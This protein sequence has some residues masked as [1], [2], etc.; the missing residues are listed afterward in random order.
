MP[1]RL[2]PID[3]TSRDF[4]SI[5][6][7]LETFAKR[8]YADTYKDFN[9][10]SFGSLMLDTVAYIGDI[11][12]FYL[13][14]QANESFLETAVEYNNVVKLA[15][16]LGYKIDRNP[17]SYGMLTFYIKVPASTTG[18][19]PDLNFAPT[20]QAGSTFSSTG[21][22]SYSL[23][24]DVVFSQ[25]TN[26]V[27]VGSVDSTS[28]LPTS[29]VIRAKGRAVSGRTAFQEVT[30]GSFERFRKVELGNQN[31]TEVISVMDSEGHRYYEVDNLSQNII[32]KA[33]RNTTATK[34]TVANILKAVPVARRFVV[35][36]TDTSTY[37]QFGYGSDSELVSEAVVDPSNL[38]LDL[39]GRNY[40]TD[41][42]FDP[43]KLISSDKFGIAPANT[44][45]RIGYRVNTT[46]D[47]NAGA[48]TI[49]VVGNP[50]VK[51]SSPATLPV[52]QRTAVLNSLEVTNEAP[53]VG[54]VSMPSADDIK[55]RVFGFYATQHRAVTTED[56]RAMCYA[57]P[58][59][60][61]AVR[62][63]NLV[64]DFDAF[65]RNL[66][67][68][69]ISENTSGKLV[70]ANQTLK[71]NLKN[72]IL[73]YKM[74]NDTV[75]ILDARIIN[76]GIKYTL[77]LDMNTSR[78]TA[79]AQANQNIQTYLAR[80]RFEI[81][82]PIRINDIYRQLNKV[83]GVVDVMGVEIVSKNGGRYAESD[84]DPERAMSADGRMIRADENTI[85]ELKFPSLDI[86]GSVR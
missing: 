43:T 20:L 61:G 2:Q 45:L 13:D 40:I 29:Y 58:T 12:S 69:V 15:R 36:S 38:M 72:W 23:L 7:D 25:S 76:F 24:Q 74:I 9:E 60:F 63:V 33:I 67:L 31:V 51:F 82:E 62:G 10:A 27:V 65:K 84:F 77:S 6:R 32:F 4:D 52:A 3:Y 54:S 21:G 73:N 34:Q 86:M 70:A 85:F 42:G 57:M 17:S 68:Y 48:D 1:K 64:R 56:Y 55:Q 78:Y 46:K 16:Q 50:L 28:G 59:K 80:N 22:G 41:A 75:D 47:V 19:G 71:D 39:N 44:T 66:N 18:P 14:Y 26:Q 81:G 49:V 37:L 8:Y 53:F 35:E 79:L 11:L 5:R 83:E 30:V